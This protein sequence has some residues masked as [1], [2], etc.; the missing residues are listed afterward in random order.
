MNQPEFPTVFRGYDPVQ[1]D[2]HLAALQ[3][4]AESAR[5]ESASGSVELTKLRQSHDALARQLEAER[6][7]STDLEEQT[8][9]VS[10]PTFADLGERIGTMLGLADE[11]A[12]AIRQSATDDVG[13]HRRLAEEASAQVRTDAD[14]YAED[15]RS[16]ADV[17]ATETLTRAKQE[18]DSIIDD[19]ARE[20]AARREEAEA[21]FE[22]QRATAAAQAAD[23][24]RT[25][26]ERREKSA[27]EFTAQMATQDQALA[28]VQE[29]ADLLAREADTERSSRSE[30]ATRLLE[31]AKAEA[32]QLVGSAKEQA[33][34]I[35][36]DSEREL[37]AATA[38]R[39]SITAQLSNVRNMLATLGGGAALGALADAP[40]QDEAP[41]ADEPP[42]EVHDE[43]V[44]DDVLEAPEDD[45]PEADVTD[46]VATDEVEVTDA[47]V[48]TDGTP[49][50][51]TAPE[52]EQPTPRQGK[53][54][55]G[56]KAGSRR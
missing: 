4:A 28:A 54:G 33:E 22:K 3:Q 9:K 21:Y 56:E 51:D 37:A 18:A 49:E 26:G 38:R 6:S 7:R 15:V 29:R 25:L 32:T 2:Q 35:R 24:E 45:A 46:E 55:K 31:G 40:A 34:R 47:V 27:A 11:E 42:V 39:D 41:A 50:T 52:D 14:R 23:F 17:E 36:R 48:E 5:Q 20:A 19:A 44:E 16:R 1:V 8:R 12:A 10:T 30:E 43:H 53:G 13:E